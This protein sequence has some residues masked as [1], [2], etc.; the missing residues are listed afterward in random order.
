MKT[1]REIIMERHGAAELALD[2]I[3]QRVVT[4]LKP[5]VPSPHAS[6]L[7]LLWIELI[8]PCRR[9]W[10]GL[11]A[12]WVVILVLNFEDHAPSANEA[13][14]VMASEISPQAM[15]I[16]TEQWRLEDEILAAT[17][18]TSVVRPVDPLVRPRSEYRLPIALT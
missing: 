7:K 17:H 6:I 18:E 15:S 2:A 10:M 12:V 13:S 14:R 16:L 11:A 1:P 4:E 3:R 8:L 5:N 9:V